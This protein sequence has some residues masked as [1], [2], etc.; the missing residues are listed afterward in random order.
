MKILVVSDSHLENEI[1]ENVIKKHPAMDAY[2]HCGDS[3]L[4]ASDPLLKKFHV[5]LGNH[6]DDYFPLEKIISIG[7][8]K[9]LILH[10]HKHNVYT[11][12][13][14]IESYMLKND[15][16]LCL[17]GHTHIPSYYKNDAI[18]IINPGSLMINR[19]SYGFGTYAIVTIDNNID[20]QFYH[21]ITH[22]ECSKKV[23]KNGRDTMNKIKYLL[24]KQK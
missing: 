13:Q 2:I 14:M 10:G 20:V 18:T 5:V 22:D 1:L 3:S 24:I 12:Y 15:I 8:K 6:D 7:G 9:I 21:H 19:A 23:L 17:H 11:D 4:K 16:D